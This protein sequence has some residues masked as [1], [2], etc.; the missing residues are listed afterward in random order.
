[1]V[2][3]AIFTDMVLYSLVVPI[4]PRY[5]VSLGASQLAIGVLF[6]SYAIA[7]LVALPILGMVSD[8]IGRRGP[9]LWG[10]VGLG[11]STLLFAVANTY[12][13]L[14]LARLL[15]GM[16]GAVTWTAGLALITDVYPAEQRGKA[17]GAALSA[18]AVGGL[19]GP[20]LGGVLYDLGGY[21]LPFLVVAGLAFADGAARALLIEELPRHEHRQRPALLGL[22][23][24]PSVV[25]ISITVV[26]TAAVFSLMEPVMPLHL[27]TDLGASSAIIGLMFSGTMVGFGATS[28]VS[29]ILSERWGRSWC[30]AGGLVILAL[31]VPLLSVPGQ[32]VLEAGLM[33]LL[34]AG[35]GLVLAP[36]LPDL[37]DAVDR[38]GGGSYASAYAIWNAF[39][40]VGMVAGPVEGGLLR[41][42]LSLRTTLIITALPLLPCIALLTVRR[43][44]L[45]WT[46]VPI[47]P[48]GQEIGR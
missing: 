14:L 10:L 1:V 25:V 2:V 29:D 27:H 39:Y 37:A 48:E 5:A 28:P 33:L 3:I 40:A 26:V 36:T 34:G 47:D 6:A 8:R 15:Q 24:D 30:I 31:T 42:A 19:V 32:L 17:L 12:A 45:S 21:R 4:L 22:A 38:L 13:L 9:M 43:R 35:T 20:A 41:S 11:G 7:L 18:T 46:V 23:R 44:H 16:A